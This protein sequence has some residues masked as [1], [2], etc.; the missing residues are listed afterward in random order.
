MDGRDKQY[1]VAGYRPWNRR[2][3]DQVIS[4]YPGR[5]TYVGGP[6]ELT[7][8]ALA[9]L[10]PRYVFFLHW[11][12][13]V[14]EAVTGAHECVCFHPTDLPYGRGG[15]PMQHMILSGADET[16]VSAFRMVEEMDAGPIYLK[17][18]MSL[19]GG[20]EEVFVRFSAVAADMI[21]EIID[22]EP[23]PVPQSGEPVCFARRRPEDSRMDGLDTLRRV[24][25]F[26]RMLDVEGY[27]PAFLECGGLR[28][29]LRRSALRDGHVEADVRITV[30]GSGAD[31]KERG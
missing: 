9:A 1:V 17:R 2:V 6:D 24:H 13:K 3:F 8:E 28:L 12:W 7:A 18:P 16:V 22:T 4:R 30:A 26:I 14:P 10:D 23:E 11:S 31:E 29:T 20:G 27:P 5:W 19:L 25:D 15:S 21:R